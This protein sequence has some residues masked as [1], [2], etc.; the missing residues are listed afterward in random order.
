MCKSHSSNLSKKERRSIERV[1]YIL[2]SPYLL[3]YFFPQNNSKTNFKK[4]KTSTPPPG[5]WFQE[6]C[7]L[8]CL[9]NVPYHLPEKTCICFLRDPVTLHVV[10]VLK[11]M[12]PSA[13]D[14]SG[15]AKKL[16]PR[17]GFVA[18]NLAFVYC[19]CYIKPIISLS[20]SLSGPTKVK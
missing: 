5:I 14:R 12:K 11:K 18:L 6:I 15:R 2:Y 3:Q 17:S 4:K 9:W 19:H 20:V 1:N 8:L 7:K 16:L 13:T 10:I